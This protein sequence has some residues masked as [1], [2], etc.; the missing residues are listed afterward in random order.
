MN[1]LRFRTTVSVIEKGI[2]EGPGPVIKLLELAR[3]PDPKVMPVPKGAFE[4]SKFPVKV[5][6]PLPATMLAV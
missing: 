6:E 3:V 2:V 4:L 1:G 5:A